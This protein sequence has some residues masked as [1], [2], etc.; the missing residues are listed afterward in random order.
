MPQVLYGFLSFGKLVKLSL[1]P[2]TA[3]G[4]W[5]ASLFLSLHL[6]APAIGDV[7]AHDCMEETPNKLRQESSTDSDG[8]NVRVTLSMCV[9]GSV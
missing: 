5:D 7:C 6:Q 3:Y 1:E 9:C 4:Y 8:S 2:G